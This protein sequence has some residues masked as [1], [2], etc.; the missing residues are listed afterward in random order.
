MKRESLLKLQMLN[1]Q[2]AKCIVLFIILIFFV[3]L[4]EQINFGNLNDKYSVLKSSRF[5][6]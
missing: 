4:Q 5:A 1:V 3:Y 6:K 2:N